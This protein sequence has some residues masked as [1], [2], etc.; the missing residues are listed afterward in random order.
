VDSLCNA[1]STQQIILRRLVPREIV[2][3]AQS[4]KRAV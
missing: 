3:D 1:E 2:L 4:P